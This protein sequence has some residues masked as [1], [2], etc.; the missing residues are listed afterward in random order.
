MYRIPIQL[1]IFLFLIVNLSC[2]RLKKKEDF[3]VTYRV[4]YGDIYP[5][6]LLISYTTSDGLVTFHHTGNTWEQEV[7]LGS[8]EIASLFV[9]ELF[10]QTADSEID[11]LQE[12]PD[13]REFAR[14]PLTAYIICEKKVVRSSGEKFTCVTLFRSEIDR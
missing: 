2:D 1:I 9:E 5:H 10:M 14:K 11:E 6:R 13:T 4:T 7:C 8:D 12:M 3:R